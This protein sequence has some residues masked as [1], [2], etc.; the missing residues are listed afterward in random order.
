MP[1]HDG[2]LDRPT[3]F[4]MTTKK[5]LRK[6][7]LPPTRRIFQSVLQN[8]RPNFDLNNP[9]DPTRLL[10]PSNSWNTKLDHLSKIFFWNEMLTI[11]MLTSFG[12]HPESSLSYC[13]KAS[14]QS[15][16]S[17]IKSSCSFMT[18]CCWLVPG[19]VTR[20]L[21]F[22]TVCIFQPFL[23]VC[24]PIPKDLWWPLHY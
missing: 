2:A 12:I 20:Y 24:I 3:F 18:S 22:M 21:T 9:P 11:L 4:T 23:S 15:S 7:S 6:S 5:L 13:L 14:R 19:A 1:A 17:T 16:I 8:N 10:L